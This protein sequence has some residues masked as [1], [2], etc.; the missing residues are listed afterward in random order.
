[1]YGNATLAFSGY[2]RG[3]TGFATFLHYCNS[4]DFNWVVDKDHARVP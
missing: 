4:T 3:D 1:M 2:L